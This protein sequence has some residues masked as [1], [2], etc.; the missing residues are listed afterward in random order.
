VRG[1]W[2]SWTLVGSGTDDL[3][4]GGE[5]DAYGNVS[6]LPTASTAAASVSARQHRSRVRLWRRAGV[7][8]KS[9]MVV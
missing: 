7:W 1:D 6:D 5:I 8:R 2:S 3:I 9:P 4:A